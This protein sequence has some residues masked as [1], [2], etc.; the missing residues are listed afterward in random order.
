MIITAPQGEAECIHSA[1]N[2]N[3]RI[4][5]NSPCFAYKWN[6]SAYSTG[7]AYVAR[8]NRQSAERVYAMLRLMFQELPL[9]F[10]LPD[11]KKWKYVQYKLHAYYLQKNNVQ[12]HGPRPVPNDRHHFNPP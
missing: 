12:R 3:P 5:A 8:E 7:T 9:L 2:E 10:A 6:R 4:F 11:R 1:K